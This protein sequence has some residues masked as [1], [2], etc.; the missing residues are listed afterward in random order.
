M[1][2]TIILRAVEPEDVDFMFMIEN[3][4]SAWFVSDT[5]AP[6]SYHLLKKYAENYSADPW[7]D[8]QIRLIAEN[9]DSGKSIGIL[10]LYDL[11]CLHSRAFVGIYLLPEYRH[12]GYGESILRA[13]FDYAEKNLMID[14]LAAYISTDNAEAIALFEK[15]GFNCSGVMKQWHRSAGK[16]F[17]IKIYQKLF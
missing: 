8:N 6:F 10:D 2:A 16:K 11:N 15:C 3:D 17:D 9:T 13:A 4:K 1:V 7:Q 5:T 14:Q 12:S